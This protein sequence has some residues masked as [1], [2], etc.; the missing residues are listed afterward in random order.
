MP[1]GEL[2]AAERARAQALRRVR[3]SSREK[4]DR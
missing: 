4:G 3:V 2:L 1:Q